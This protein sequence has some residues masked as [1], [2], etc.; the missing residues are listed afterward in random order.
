MKKREIF[1]FLFV[2][3]VFS[4][5]SFYTGRD[6]ATEGFKESDVKV[7]QEE[8]ILYSFRDNSGHRV[9]VLEDRE[10]NIYLPINEDSLFLGYSVDKTE[11]GVLLTKVDYDS[12]VDINT[13]TFDSVIFTNEDIYANELTLFLNWTTWCPDCKVL[14]ESLSE[15]MDILEEQGIRVIGLPIYNGSFDEEKEKIEGILSEYNLDFVN[16][17]CTDRMKEQLQS[18]L[19]NIPSIVLVDNRGKILYDN[20]KVNL[21]I[22]DFLKDLENIDICNEC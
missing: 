6:M 12:F 14:L 8:D 19:E 2:I 3:L 5:L 22:S 1:A 18:N 7:Y 21:V 16:L 4:L 17:V 10:G 13:T 20:D 11:D 9:S 15:N